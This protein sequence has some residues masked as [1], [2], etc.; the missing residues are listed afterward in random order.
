[1]K[2]SGNEMYIEG[3]KPWADAP[4]EPIPGQR[5]KRN[6]IYPGWDSP[7]KIQQCLHC[8]NPDCSGR[9]PSKPRKKVGLPR[10]PMPEDFP[11]KEKLLRYHELIDH[12]GVSSSVISRWKKELREKGEK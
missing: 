6:G 9:C 2:L 4:S 10:I 12:Y 8:T 11:E 5:R 7:E 1:M 3:R